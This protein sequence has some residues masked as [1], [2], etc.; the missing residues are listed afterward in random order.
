MANHKTHKKGTDYCKFIDNKLCDPEGQDA[1][2]QVEKDELNSLTTTHQ[3]SCVDLS[4]IVQVAVSEF[5]GNKKFFIH[6]KNT[7]NENKVFHVDL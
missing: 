6:Y 5:E 2:T 7:S 3:E 1:I 4:E